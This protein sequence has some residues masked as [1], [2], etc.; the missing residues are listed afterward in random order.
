M[1]K[2]IFVEQKIVETI[3]EKKN[4]IYATENISRKHINTAVNGESVSFSCKI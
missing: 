3:F 4:C 1:D 2:N